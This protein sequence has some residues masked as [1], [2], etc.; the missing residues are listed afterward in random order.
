MNLA[1]RTNGLSQAK[2]VDAI[3]RGFE[4][5]ATIVTCATQIAEGR[6]LPKWRAKLMPAR[7]SQ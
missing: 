7:K 3:L 2:G 6:N 4:V 1:C 5:R